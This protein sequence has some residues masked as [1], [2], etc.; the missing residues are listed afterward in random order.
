MAVRAVETEEAG[1]VA[2]T[3]AVTAVGSGEAMGEAPVEERAAVKAAARGE[4]TAVVAREAV[5]MAA[6]TAAARAAAR[7][8]ETAVVAREAGTAAARAAEKAAARAAVAKAR[9]EAARA[10]AA[11]VPGKLRYSRQRRLRGSLARSRRWLP[12]GPRHRHRHCS[13]GLL[14]SR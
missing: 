8:E 9:A 6:A 12:T 10:V 7:G 11:A 14:C 4:E 5:V 3:E 2:V 1:M 13:Q